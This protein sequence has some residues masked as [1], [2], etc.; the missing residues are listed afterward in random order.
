MNLQSPRGQTRFFL[1]SLTRTW[2]NAERRWG[3]EE[4]TAEVTLQK[5]LVAEKKREEAETQMCKIQ[6]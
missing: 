2:V 1:G 3:E 5:T 6:K 4:A